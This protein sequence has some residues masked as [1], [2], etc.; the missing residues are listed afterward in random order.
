VNSLQRVKNAIRREAI[1]DIPVSFELVGETDLKELYVGVPRNWKPKVYKPF[2]F[3]VEDYNVEVGAR[4]ED[5]WGVVWGYGDTCAAAGIPLTAPLG[6]IDE[7]AGYEFPDPYGPGRFDRLLPFVEA[8][9]EKYCYVTW[10][11]LLFERLH[12]LLGFEKSLVELATNTKKVEHALDKIVEF[13]LGLINNLADT[14]KGSVQAFASTDDWG[15]QQGMFVNPQVWRKVFK[16]RYARI[17]DEIHRRGLDFWIHSDGKIGEI[18]PDFIEIGVDVFNLNTP[19]LLGI[20]EF[21]QRFQGQSC[22]CIYIDMQKT[23]VSGSR[24]EIVKDAHDLVNYWSN[25]QGSGVLAMDYR[26]NEIY[27]GLYSQEEILER[28]KVALGA[29]KEAFREKTDE[30]RPA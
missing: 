14:F 9:R 30:G 5:E 11:G 22:F 19:R 27:Q 13:D 24:E 3:D 15:G 26:G 4:R 8:S 2:V 21:G 16:P 10:F 18:I 1:D 29:F 6:D 28:K 17:A 7:I 25:E 23:A 20:K 12:F